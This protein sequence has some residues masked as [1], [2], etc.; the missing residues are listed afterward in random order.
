LSKRP[1]EPLG[2]HIVIARR[3]D[4]AALLRFSFNVGNHLLVL[5]ELGAYCDA[6]HYPEEEVRDM[7]FRSR[8]RG[9]DVVCVAQRPRKL[10]TDFVSQAKRIVLYR[11]QDPDD[12]AF[13]QR[14]LLLSEEQRASLQTLPRGKRLLIDKSFG[15]LNLKEPF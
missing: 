3:A 14:R 2:R 5:E 4:F 8:V 1:D 15:G 11:V 13:L 6:D 7:A 10:P 12:C 9:I